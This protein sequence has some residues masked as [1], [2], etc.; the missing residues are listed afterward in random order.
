[1]KEFKL[2][3][4]CQC[5]CLTIRLHPMQ[6]G[7]CLHREASGGCCRFWHP[8]KRMFKTFCL[9][10]ARHCSATLRKDRL[11]RERGFKWIRKK[12]KQT[13]NSKNNKK[14]HCTLLPSSELKENKIFL[15]NRM[16]HIY[17]CEPSPLKSLGLLPLTLLGRNLNESSHIKHQAFELQVQLEKVSKTVTY[18]CDLDNCHNLSRITLNQRNH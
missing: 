1:M 12:L 17:T 15:C 9:L 18:I 4:R 7:F 6:S 5:H 8:F 2:R 3:I 13:K 16:S 11:E 10:S 14:S